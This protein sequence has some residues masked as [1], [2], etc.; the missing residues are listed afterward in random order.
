MPGKS[1]QFGKMV[2]FGKSVPVCLAL[3]A[4]AF[5]CRVAGERPR[6][7]GQVPKREV[8]AVWLTTLSGLDWPSTRAT[9][10]ESAERQRR[11][12]RGMLDGLRAAGV[13]TV[14]LQTRI[15][16]TVI[17]PS[18][19]EPWD[20]CL[21]GTPGKSPGYDPLAFAV[22]EC[23]RRGMEVQAWVVSVPLGKWNAIGC[24]EARA[25][26]PGLVMRVGEDGYLD[27]ANPASHA[28]LA[29]ICG[30]IA[31][32]Y[33]VDGIHLDYIR[34]PETM[35]MGI[36]ASRAR[37]NITGM[38]RAVRDAVKGAKPWVK[39]SCAPIGKFSDLNR[40]PSKG[41]NAYG[42]GFQDVRE[43]LSAGL[44]D[45]VYPM[46]YFRGDQ[47]YPFAFDWKEHSAGRTVVPGLGA[48]LLSPSG[49]NWPL[50]E[51]QAQMGVARSAGMGHAFF[52]ARFLLDDVKGL[53][54]LARD[55][56]GYPALVPPIERAG[57]VS[58]P[59]PGTVDVARGSG[60]DLV[61]WPAVTGLEGGTL[62]NV[63]AGR[64]YPVDV[65]NARN[66]VAPRVRESSLS[67]PARGRGYFYAVTA[68]D[69]YG[70]E[71]EPAQMPGRAGGG[72]PFLANDGRVMDVPSLT[73]VP[74]A[75]RVLV[76]SLAGNAVARIRCV[77][78]RAD[79]SG[80]ANGLYIVY[81][82]DA[83]PRPERLGLL[84]VRRD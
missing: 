58:V 13:N 71:S 29:A 82:L 38:V 83:G 67:V 48:Y 65:G 28:Y 66:L 50:G 55:F 34:Y 32:N 80:V 35:R 7:L 52:R 26:R 39:V 53:Y 16:G 47:F 79:I 56:D 37:A 59:S 60:L 6:S 41:W 46:M 22:E 9:G 10:P 45:Q 51:I 36:P 3:L 33:D 30:E 12:L 19:L 31:R 42:R 20:G 73:G 84:S 74:G 57:R 69:R 68:M 63:Y 5:S 72:Y 21:T 77:G 44:V 8:R 15:R 75:A 2:V 11:E 14:L 49:E 70:N 17:Y 24:R 61:S 1:Y 78:G 40:Y 25:R 27:P 43:W 4:L 23:H 54:G 62:Y 81:S 76:E 64:E 18:G